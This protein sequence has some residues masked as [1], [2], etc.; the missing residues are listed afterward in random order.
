M[1]SLKYSEDE[2]KQ[3]TEKIVQE[4]KDEETCQIQ[5]FLNQIHGNAANL[6]DKNN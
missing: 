4:I 6:D 2:L 5:M 3:D 1:L